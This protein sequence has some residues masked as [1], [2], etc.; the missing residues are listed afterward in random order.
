MVGLILA[1]SG[2]KVWIVD[3]VHDDRTSG[4]AGRVE[5]LPQRPDSHVIAA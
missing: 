2:R 1:G 4:R 5:E 3:F